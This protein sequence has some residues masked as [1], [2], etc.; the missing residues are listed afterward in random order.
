MN[1]SAAESLLRLLRA[2]TL[3]P[4][5]YLLAAPGSPSPLRFCAFFAKTTAYLMEDS[6]WSSI[7]FESLFLTF[8]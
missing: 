7:L 3:F 4:D 6:G 8:S 5:E 1:N 2:S